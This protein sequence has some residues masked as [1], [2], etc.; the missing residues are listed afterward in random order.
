MSLLQSSAGGHDMTETLTIREL[1]TDD[2]IAGAF[3][4]MSVLRPHLQPETFVSQVRQ[5][6]REGYRLFAGL[7]GRSIVV[8]AGIRDG[9]T[10][11]RGPH[12]FVDDLVTAPS[13]QGRGYGKAMLRHVAGLAREKGLPR[14]WLDSRDTAKSF[15]EQMGFKVSTGAPCSIEVERLE[16]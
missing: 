11:S 5:Q 6:A 15:Y 3:D 7:T 13:V 12:L 16:A 4:L 9:L 2:E 14:V 10:L 8:L 1:T